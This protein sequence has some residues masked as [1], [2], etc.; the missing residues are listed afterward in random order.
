MTVFETPYPE[1]SE[2]LMRIGASTEVGILIGLF[3]HLAMNRG[4]VGG[5]IGNASPT[6]L[7]YDINPFHR[8]N[9]S[10]TTT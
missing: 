7:Q 3:K 4:Q 6:R 2:R 9:G 10:C 5:N 8:L 1:V